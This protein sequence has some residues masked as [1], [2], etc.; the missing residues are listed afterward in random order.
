[1]L[2][3]VWLTERFALIGASYTTVRMMQEFRNIESRDPGP[4]NEGLNLTCTNDGG[5]KV[6]LF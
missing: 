1:M 6:A 5:A 4:W 2:T 3:V